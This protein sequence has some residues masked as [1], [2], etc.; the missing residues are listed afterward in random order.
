M[1]LGALLPIKDAIT[2]LSNGAEPPHLCLAEWGVPRP[3]PYNKVEWDDMYQEISALCEQLGSNVLACVPNVSMLESYSCQD[4]NHFHSFILMPINKTE[5]LTRVAIALNIR[6]APLDEGMVKIDEYL[7]VDFDKMLIRSGNNNYS[8]MNERDSLF[9]KYLFDRINK[10]V[11]TKELKEN[12][13]FPTGEKKAEVH[14]RVSHLRKLI[15]DSS[16][17]EYLI[18]NRRGYYMLKS[19]SYPEGD[20]VLGIRGLLKQRK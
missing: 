3:P 13:I 12:A 15:Q 16:H 5:L 2:V 14:R 1:C 4:E 17:T 8:S 10:W 18:S 6:P 9:L 11:S 19:A 7:A 20:S